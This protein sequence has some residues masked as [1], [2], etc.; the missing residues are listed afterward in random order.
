MRRLLL[1]L[2]ISAF[3]LILLLSFKPAGA[4]QDPPLL[5]CC[6]HIYAAGSNLGWSTALLTFTRERTRWEPADQTIVDDMLRAGDHVLAAQRTCSKFLPAWPDSGNKQAFLL[7]RATYLRNHPDPIGR[8]HVRGSI[9]STYQWAEPLRRFKGQDAAGN[10]V[11]AGAD[12]CEEKYFKMG[13]LLGAAAQTLKI[14]DEHGRAGFNDWSAI[15]R[16][17]D[18]YL[19]QFL[20][21]LKQYAAV[22][23]LSVSGACADVGFDSLQ[24]SIFGVWQNLPNDVPKTIPIIDADWDILMNRLRDHCVCSTG[25]L[26]YPG[27]AWCILRRMQNPPAPPPRVCF[28]F[29][30]ADTNLTTADRMAVILN[31][32]CEVTTYAA[33]QGWE[34]DPNFSEPYSHQNEALNQVEKLRPFGGDA[35]GCYGEPKIDP[36]PGSKTGIGMSASGGLDPEAVKQEVDHASSYKARLTYQGPSITLR[37]DRNKVNS[38]VSVSPTDVHVEWNYTHADGAIDKRVTTMHL[39]K[40]RVVDPSWLQGPCTNIL[41]QVSGMS[42]QAQV[43]R[44]YTM[45]DERPANMQWNARYDP[46]RGAWVFSVQLGR[47]PPWLLHQ[48][49]GIR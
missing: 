17:A 35:Y 21:I 31:N 5:E 7:E 37:F 29:R 45:G 18:D 33:R 25:P 44:P 13:F 12:T 39:E 24:S 22:R 40:G 43:L 32:A 42:W 16:Y 2:V 4:Q 6:Y 38:T 23:P 41:V 34:V 30:V 11:I 46:S 10:A 9:A 1:H 48:S 20:D 19:R 14:A 36:D 27:P 3:S 47:V 28:D 26:I 15:A 49:G 8:E